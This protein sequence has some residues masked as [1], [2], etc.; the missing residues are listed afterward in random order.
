MSANHSAKFTQ[1]SVANHIIVMSGSA[2]VGLMVMFMS[3]LVDMYFL[4]LLGEVEIASAIGYAGSILY[5]LLSANIGL[6]VACAALV[7]KQLGAEDVEEARLS[8]TNSLV[9]AFILLAPVVVLAWL[10]IPE[11]LGLIG[12]KGQALVFSTQYLEIVIPSVLIIALS[13]TAGAVMRADGD[14]KGAMFLTMIGGVANAVLD[15]I[16]IFGFGLGV[17]GAAIATFLSRVLMLAYAVYVIVYRDQL[18]GRFIKPHYLSHLKEYFAIAVPAVLTNL[19]TPIGI[20]YVTYVMASFGDSAVAGNAI[21]GR[22]QMVAFAGILALS[23][24]VGPIAGQNWGANKIDRVREVLTDSL[25]IIITY[26]LVVC[27][28]LWLTAPYIVPLFNASD[29]ANELVY[30]FCYGLSTMYFFHGMSYITNA[31]FN[32]LGVPH[33]S[34]ILNFSKATIGTIPF[35][36]IGAAYGQASG[37]FWGLFVGTAVMGLIGWLVAMRLVKK[38]KFEP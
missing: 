10:F 8:V 22:I 6:S 1:G 7:S 3:D 29:E 38:L 14:A 23:G 37:A 19:S 13:M 5:F 27:T 33:Y 17:Q 21:I 34:T 26:C 36:A 9:S 11:L 4:G 12:A 32:N 18:F 15:P 25:K 2:S 30:L 16:F 31:M 28:L 20:A 35:V 24:V